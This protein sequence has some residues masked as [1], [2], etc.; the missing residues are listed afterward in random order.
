[1]IARGVLFRP[2]AIGKVSELALSA[3]QLTTVPAMVPLD[4][5]LEIDVGI[6]GAAAG[7]ELRAVENGTDLELDSAVSEEAVSTRICAKGPG[8][9]GSVNARVELRTTGGSARALL[10]TR[11]LAP[12]E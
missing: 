5:C 12:S 11:L 7:V 6:Q 4:R 9:S 8:V 2:S 1:M 3:D 10:A